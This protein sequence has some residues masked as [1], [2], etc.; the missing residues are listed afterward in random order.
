[1][2]RGS[3]KSRFNL[4]AAVRRSNVGRRELLLPSAS[5]PLSYSTL[6]D[7]YFVG[8]PKSPTSISKSL[9]SAATW[10]GPQNVHDQASVTAGPPDCAGL[11]RLVHRIWPKRCDAWSTPGHS[12]IWRKPRSTVSRGTLPVSPGRR[13]SLAGTQRSRANPGTLYRRKKH[14]RL[15]FPVGRSGSRNLGLIN[16]G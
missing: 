14:G 1:M 3:S 9:D 10:P 2:P 8:H 5:F 12:T 7:K 13:Q 11:S 6:C 16:R 4:I 15:T